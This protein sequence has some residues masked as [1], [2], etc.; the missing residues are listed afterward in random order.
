[1][2]TVVAFAF[3]GFALLN[4]WCATMETLNEIKAT[5][6]T[7]RHAIDDRTFDAHFF[8]RSTY[9]SEDSVMGQAT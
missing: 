1:M 4:V 3:A 7:L 9:D 8:S 2:L 5:L 6:T